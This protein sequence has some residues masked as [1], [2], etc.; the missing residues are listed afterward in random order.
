MQ[1]QH[2]NVTRAPKALIAEIH[3]AGEEL[4]KSPLRR[5]Y[6]A[7]AMFLTPQRNTSDLDVNR[8]QHDLAKKIHTYGRELCSEPH[9][10][11]YTACAQFQ[12]SSTPPDP[13]GRKQMP[14][15]RGTAAARNRLHWSDSV[16]KMDKRQSAIIRTTKQLEREQ[17]LDAKWQGRIPKVSCIAAI[18]SG[19]DTSFRLK[20]FMDNFQSQRYE[21]LRQLVLVHQKSDTKLG[22]LLRTYA[23][24]SHI[25][26]AALSDSFADSGKFPSTA[27]LLWC[28]AGRR[29]AYCALELR[30]VASSSALGLASACNCIGC[31]AG[32]FDEDSQ[33]LIAGGRRP[34]R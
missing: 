6:S 14:N 18:P 3:D 13:V 22:E 12:Q 28:L 17:V 4:C 30:R 29:R 21:G 16:K 7:C 5:N 8:L 10:V 26:V 19:A 25:K 32:E 15:L 20:S 23:D 2:H 24:G 11:N 31:S 1:H 33:W 27:V 34:L 9:R